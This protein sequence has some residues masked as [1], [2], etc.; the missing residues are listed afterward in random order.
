MHTHV[1]TNDRGT[2]YS[3]GQ[4]EWEGGGA[5]GQEKNGG[6]EGVEQWGAGSHLGLKVSTVAADWGEDNCFIKGVIAITS[7]IF[8]EQSTF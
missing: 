7:L 1:R 8:Q 5:L 6:G 4:V 2:N 3:D